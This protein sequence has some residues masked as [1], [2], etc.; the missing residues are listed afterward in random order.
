MLNGTADDFLWSLFRLGILEGDLKR[1][2]EWA[3]SLY[4]RGLDL[5]KKVGELVTDYWV[6]EDRSILLSL[7]RVA[8]EGFCLDVEHRTFLT[9]HLFAGGELDLD[10]AYAFLGFD[11][12]NVADLRPSVRRVADV[13]WLLRQ[14]SDACVMEPSDDTLLSEALRGLAKE[15]T[16]TT[17]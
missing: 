6:S 10:Q 4:D 12:V 7:A 15:L 9:A 13:H 11:G 17:E 3:A 1:A 14:D 8:L 2:A 16:D 5:P